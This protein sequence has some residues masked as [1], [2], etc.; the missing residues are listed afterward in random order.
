MKTRAVGV[1][2]GGICEMEPLS[3]YKESSRLALLFQVSDRVDHIFDSGLDLPVGQAFVATARWH[4]VVS[5]LALD[6]VDRALE[7][8]LHA[9]GDARLPVRIIG[10]GRGASSAHQMAGAAGTHPDRAPF[11]QHRIGKFRHL[12]AGGGL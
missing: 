4:L 2:L 12:E 3:T 7:K 1:R 9:L 6:A 10:Y 5:V 8:G 11:G